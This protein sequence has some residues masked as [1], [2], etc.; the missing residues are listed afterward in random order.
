MKLPKVRDSKYSSVFND[1]LEDDQGGIFQIRGK[2]IFRSSKKWKISKYSFTHTCKR[3]KKMKIPPTSLMLT[4]T[5][6]TQTTPKNKRLIQS[7][8][9]L[10][11]N[12]D[13]HNNNDHDHNDD[14]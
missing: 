6:S 9:S 7:S 8:L 12:D 3:E 13:G 1:I 2:I 10:N 14:E 5:I 4:T 11:N